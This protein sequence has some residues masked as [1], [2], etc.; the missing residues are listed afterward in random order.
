MAHIGQ[1]H[2]L[3]VGS[4]L[5]TFLRHADRVKVACLAQ[6]VNVIAPIM[7]RTGGGAW[8]QT[9]FYP[10]MHVSNFARGTALRPQVCS[11]A[12]DC[13]D[14]TDVPYIDATAALDGDG[15][16]TVFAVNR[17]MEED[18]LLEADL[19]AFGELRMGG[20]ILLHHDDVKAVNS[21]ENP[22]NVA[23]V[24]GEGGTLEGG[25]LSVRLP[26]LSW[27]VLRLRHV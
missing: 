4:M 3:L 11:P 27:N 22:Q 6:L 2:Q 1:V 25:R 12:Y 7:T 10:Y 21:E 18:I 13:A 24:Q 19:R 20:H 23:P 8:A 17:S 14:Y 9:I 15:S 5:I 26:R 16:V